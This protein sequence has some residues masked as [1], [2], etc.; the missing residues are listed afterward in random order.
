[1]QKIFKANIKE[2]FTSIQGEGPYVGQKHIFVRFCKCNLKCAFCDTNF[3]VKSSKEYSTVDLYEQLKEIDC[4]TISFTGGEPLSDVDFLIEFLKEYKE[5][6]NKKIYLETNGTLTQELF[7][8]I[9]Y[10]DIVSMDIK[11]ASVTK[12]RSNFV[13]NKEFIKIANA[14]NKEI[15]IKV[16]FDENITQKEIK[17]S[18]ELAK[19]YDNLLVLQPKMPFNKEIDFNNIYNKF[20]SLYK[21]VRLIPQTHKFLNVE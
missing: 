4:D 19:E 13:K 1:M 21:N 14:N 3:D 10:I 11:L 6:L 18:V 12:Q 7:K 9:K 8:I 2:I 20:Y 15:F 16:V 17:M 5:K